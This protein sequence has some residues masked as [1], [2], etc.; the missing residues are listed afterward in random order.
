[1]NP[2]GRHLISKGVSYPSDFY[3]IVGFLSIILN[4]SAGIAP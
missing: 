1:M 4:E 3:E 2:L